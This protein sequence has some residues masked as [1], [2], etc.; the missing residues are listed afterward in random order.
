MTRLFDAPIRWIVKPVIREDYCELTLSAGEWDET[1]GRY[2]SMYRV[3]VHWAGWS[4]SRRNT[5][6]RECETTREEA[7]RASAN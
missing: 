2:R 1:S 6:I 5:L 4:K 7:K 3:R